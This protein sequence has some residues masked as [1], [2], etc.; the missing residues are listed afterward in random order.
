MLILISVLVSAGSVA[1][2][3]AYMCRVSALRNGWNELAAR[4]GREGSFDGVRFGAQSAV[5][6]G[7]AFTGTLILG[8]GPSGFYLRGGLL[9]HL[10]HPPILVPWSDITVER[11]ERTY[12]S[13][14]ALRF[15]A[16]P[17]MSCELSDATLERLAGAARPEWNVALPW[18]PA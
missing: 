16:F 10:F 7:F 13:G 3:W 18:S 8:V 14:Y 6:N 2:M 15:A 1:V 4:Y 5:L 11:L 17:D 12:S 9:L